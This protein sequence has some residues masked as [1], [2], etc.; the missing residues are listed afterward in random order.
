MATEPNKQAPERLRSRVGVAQ[1][2]A[3]HAHARAVR[4]VARRA[5]ELER[6][7]AEAV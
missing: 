1:C 5:T 3:P 4:Q 2:A 7:G 6:K